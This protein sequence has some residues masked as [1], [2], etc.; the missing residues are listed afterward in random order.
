MRTGR[1]I[2]FRSYAAMT[3]EWDAPDKVPGLEFVR[4]VVVSRVA[5]AVSL[6]DCDPCGLLY[7]FTL[8]VFFRRAKDISPSPPCNSCTYKFVAMYGLPTH[9]YSPGTHRPPWRIRPQVQS[10]RK[11]SVLFVWRRNAEGCLVLLM[12]SF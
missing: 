6:P 7:C 3:A 1:A 4:S 11:H 9:S 12:A 10:D 2:K 8:F 5:V